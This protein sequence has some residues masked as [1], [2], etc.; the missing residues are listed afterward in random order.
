MKHEREDLVVV[1]VLMS[2]DPAK[3]IGQQLL[4]M[5]SGVVVE[6]GDIDHFDAFDDVP[7][8]HVMQIDVA[9]LL[10]RDATETSDQTPYVA[11]IDIVPLQRGD[12]FFTVRMA[13]HDV[14]HALLHGRVV[15]CPGYADIIRQV[16]VRHTGPDC[17]VGQLA[18]LFPIGDDRVQVHAEFPA[19][20]AEVTFGCIGIPSV[21]KMN[22]QR[23]Q[24]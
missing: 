18:R 19:H 20:F 22:C 14:P 5:L 1:V 4:N 13:E 6:V 11:A 2:V 24:S 8:K 23:P 15:Q 7:V 10:Q 17:A 12:P 16:Y 3:F 9:E 21:V